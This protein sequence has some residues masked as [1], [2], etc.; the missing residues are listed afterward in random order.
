VSRA[1]VWFATACAALSLLLACFFRYD[2]V[3][4]AGGERGHAY[5]L[6]RWTGAVTL[7]GLDQEIS[8]EVVE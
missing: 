4:V 8:V 2:I 1:A 6:D 3:P 7:L 5:K